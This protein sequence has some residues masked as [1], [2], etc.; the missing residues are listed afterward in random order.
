M[1]RQTS[2]MMAAA[3]VLGLAGPAFAQTAGTWSA[4]GDTVTLAA[5]DGSTTLTFQCD[6]ASSSMRVSAN[7]DGSASQPARVTVRANNGTAYSVPMR[8]ASGGALSGTVAMNLI[9]QG[10]F[11]PAT[12]LI[13]TFPPTARPTLIADV[14]PEFTTVMANC[15]RG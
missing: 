3:F 6:V 9:N 4:S 10:A 5:A 8:A 13:I 2:L 15:P 11:Q 14:V 7:N 1:P 12:T